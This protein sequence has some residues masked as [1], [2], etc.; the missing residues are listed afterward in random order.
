MEN[1]IK[2]FFAHDHLNYARLKP[3]HLAQ[4]NA[5]EQDDPATWDA[6]K[7]GD[8]VVAKSEVPF[9]QLF[10]D[11]T[12]E[13]EIKMLK[14]HG[15]MVGLSQDE[16]ALDRLVTTTPHLTH[17]VKQFL[18]AFP[19]ASRSTDRSEHYQ[20][21]GAVAIRSRA[22][23][24]KLRESIELHCAGNT[25]MKKTPLKNILISACSK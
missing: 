10:T 7:S 19:K 6:L 25:F 11:Q 21:S 3:V 2:Y 8:F 17:L 13:Q 23:A 22:N 9:T 5:L 20:L 24:V 4:M 1:N 12:L 15:G 16:A 14:R 18:N